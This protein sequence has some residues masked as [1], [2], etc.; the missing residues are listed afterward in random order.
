MLVGPL[1]DCPR[2]HARGTT[3]QTHVPM[4][5]RNP[6]GTGA[7]VGVACSRTTPLPR[8]EVV[9]CHPAEPGIV[10]L[11][12]NALLHHK[13]NFDWWGPRDP[14]FKGP[15]LHHQLLF[16]TSL[17]NP[18]ERGQKEAIGHLRHESG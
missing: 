1:A 17:E 18:S 15:T 13:G 10:C 5:S 7:G 6:T 3:R 14:S 8:E 4:D 2:T 16:F 11:L 9:A 12:Q